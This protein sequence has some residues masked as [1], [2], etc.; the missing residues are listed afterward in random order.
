MKGVSNKLEIKETWNYL[1]FLK[2]YGIIIVFVSILIIFTIALD[3]FLT[4]T[5]IMNVLTQTSM[6]GIIAIGLTFCFIANEFDLSVGSICGLAG[7]LTAV[8]LKNEFN[9]VIAIVT[10]LSIGL[11]FG[12]LNGLSITKLRMPS[13]ITTI[14]T[15]FVALGINYAYSEKVAVSYNNGYFLFIGRGKIGLIPFPVIMLCIVFLISKILLE[16]YRLGTYLYTIG[17]NR[18]TAR[19]S[20]INID[21]YIIFSFAISGLFS[22]VS[23]IIG[24][25]VFASAQPSLGQNFVLDAIAGVFLGKTMLRNGEPH[26][27]GSLI[28]VLMMAIITNGFS[29]ANLGFYYQDIAKALIILAAVAFGSYKNYN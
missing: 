24:A 1:I 26:L 23:G 9:M 29:L 12:I 18:I 10:S 13:L 14:A 25:S 5:N 6:L 15:S 20:G 2:K 21:I 17:G 4:L 19:F 28:G 22:A 7:V 3:D 8:M 11:A 27:L 16:K